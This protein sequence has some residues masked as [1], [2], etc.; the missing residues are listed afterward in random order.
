MKSANSNN[1]NT[2][3]SMDATYK[4]NTC[5]FPLIITATVDKSHKFHLVSISITQ[6]ED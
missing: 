6:R 2:Y 4:I 3:L 5:D 1:N